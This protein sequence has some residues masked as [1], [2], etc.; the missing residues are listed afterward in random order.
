MHTA[1]LC[2]T[3]SKNVLFHNKSRLIN[4]S[5]HLIHNSIY[6]FTLKIDKTGQSCSTQKTPLTLSR[7]HT[8]NVNYNFKTF[9]LILHLLLE[10]A[11][12]SS[13]VK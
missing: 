10:S 12:V 5:L 3:L 13:T 4:L 1:I 11:Q 9:Q 7:E 6:S 8:R 2:R